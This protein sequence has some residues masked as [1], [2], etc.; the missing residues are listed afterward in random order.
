[1]K[2]TVTIEAP[3]DCLSCNF[4]DYEQGLCLALYNYNTDEGEKHS[5]IAEKNGARP[6]YCPLAEKKTTQC[7]KIRGK[8]EFYCVA[9]G[10]TSKAMTN[11]CTW[12]GAEVFPEGEKDNGKEA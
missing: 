11:F 10:M 4:C 12:C 9:C 7:M 3:K 1:M 5:F 8:N 2:A 6:G